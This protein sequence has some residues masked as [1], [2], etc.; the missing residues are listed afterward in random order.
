MVE[1]SWDDSTDVDFIPY[2]LED[3]V[4]LQLVC[5]NFECVSRMYE[6]TL[7]MSKECGDTEFRINQCEKCGF[8]YPEAC[9]GEEPDALRSAVCTTKAR[10]ATLCYLPIVTRE[11]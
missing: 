3:L 5:P 2:V 7:T 4:R 6:T 9:L 1:V 10:N 8:Y 11:L